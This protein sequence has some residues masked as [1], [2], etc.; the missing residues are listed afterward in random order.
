[1]QILEK[2]KDTNVEVEARVLITGATGF[3]GSHLIEYL[4]SKHLKVF[5]VKRRRSKMENVSHITNPNLEWVLL[6]VTDAHSI[7]RVLNEVEPDYIFHLAAQSFIPASWSA[8]QECFITNAVGTINVLEAVL[9][10]GGNPV[11]QVAG[12]SEEYGMV[13]A[14]EVPILET[15]PLRPLSPY[16]VSKVAADLYAQQ[17]HK[18]YGLKTIITRAFN[19]TGPRRG[20]EFVCSAFAKQIIDGGTIH[21]GNLKAIRDFTDVRDMARAYWLSMIYCD[22]GTPYNICEGSGHTIEYVLDE[23]LN[24]ASELYAHTF[25]RPEIEF[26]ETRSRP[27]D[28]E[29]L[30]GDC[31]KFHAKTGWTPTIPFRQTLKDLLLYWAINLGKTRKED[32]E[33]N[34]SS[35]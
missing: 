33:N 12:S 27:A 19:H 26:D 15:N 17:M 4:L 8:P 30:V 16:G 28:V 6:D 9:R 3:M 1:M 11:V 24:L 10:Y 13:K 31:I 20:E 18:S 7:H 23:L 32:Y 22:Y 35:T 14:N 29:L 25:K 21:V 34:Y 2:P 5:G